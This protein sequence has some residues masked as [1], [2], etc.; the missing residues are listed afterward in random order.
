MAMLIYNHGFVER[1]LSVA[2]AEA[3]ILAILVCI[4][5]FIQIVWSN[6]KRIY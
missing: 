2:M 3:L 5:S 4:V 1:R 6:K